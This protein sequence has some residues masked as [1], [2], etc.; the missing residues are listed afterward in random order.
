MTKKDFIFLIVLVGFAGVRFFFFMPTPLPYDSA[1]GKNVT[2]SGVVVDVPDVR[3]NN[4]RFTIRPSGG[5]S[6][7]L[8]VSSNILLDKNIEYGDGVEVS[9][10]L[11]TPE[12]FITSSGN[13]FNY[14]RYLA[15]KDIYFIIKNANLA[16]SSEGNASKIKKILFRIRDAFMKNINHSID[17]PKSDLAN[18]LL[19]GARGGFNAEIR[20]EFVSTG[21]IHIIA[22]SGYNVT[23]VA[24]QVMRSLGYLFAQT[25]SVVI[26][27]VFVVLF[28]LMAGASA[29]AVRAGLMALIMLFARLTGRMYDAGRAL[30]IT[31]LLM[32]AYDPRVIADISFQLSFIATFG[33]L[34]IT[35]KVIG[36]VRF[37]PLRFGIREIG[38]TTISAT[39]SVLPILLYS[40]GIL[41]IVS[42]PTNILILPLLPATMFFAFCAGLFGFVAQVVAL[43]F[44]FVAHIL[45]SYILGI[46]HFFASLPF[47]SVTIK[48]FPLFITLILYALILW[49]VFFKKP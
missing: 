17:P 28:V 24:E 39:I 47:A 35:P 11:E 23:I 44:A 29:T 10:V 36:W 34:Y 32:I 38:A 40:T 31:A 16:L 8:A 15:N 49:W 20:D 33:V 19:L 43:P 2:V 9:G 37:L 26:G 1:V 12:N 6:N 3:E 5:E 42:L 46:I 13:E 4:T 41:S 27:G 45:L 25:V 22:L 21:T 7:L 30:V 48:S 14:K 18:G